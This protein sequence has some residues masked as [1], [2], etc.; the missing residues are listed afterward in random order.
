MSLSVRRLE[1]ALR[2][3]FYR[4]H[5]DENGCGLCQFV[6]WWVPTWERWANRTA[7]ENRRLRD[8]L[9]DRGEYDGYLLCRD[10]APVGWAQVGPRDRL[11]NLAQ[12]YSLDPDPTAW[13]ITCLLLT[14]P[15]RGRG[16]ARHL[17]EGLLA[18]LPARGASRGLPAS[19][20]GSAGG[21]NLDRLGAALLR[22][23]VPSDPGSPSPPSIRATP[24]TGFR[25][26]RTRIIPSWSS[27]QRRS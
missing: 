1:P 3:D 24:W 17:L 23:R 26:R 25:R 4:L 12:S 19:R 21:G 22:T 20:R 5:S 8:S 11:E 13:A 6:A 15:S 10:D 7:E 2:R 14:A 9:F 16:W 27:V 18:D